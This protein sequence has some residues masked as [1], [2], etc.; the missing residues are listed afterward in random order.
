MS[1]GNARLER[2]LAV[3]LGIVIAGVVAAGIFWWLGR[4][5][6]ADGEPALMEGPE[7]PDFVLTERSGEPFGRQH[8]RGTV[9]IADFIFTNCAGICPRM[10]AEMAR[11]Q[12]DLP[13][14]VKFVSFSVDPARDTPDAL[15]AFADRYGAVRG[16]WYFLTGPRET[17]VELAYRI[18]A[19]KIEIPADHGPHFVL[20]DGLGRIRGYYDSNDAER[21][22]RLRQDARRLVAQARPPIPVK[23]LPTLNASLNG[24][25]AVLLLAG[26]GF[27]RSKRVAAHKA[28]MVAALG[29]SVLFLVSYLTYHHYAGTVPFRGQGWV[30][31]VYFGILI[32]HTVLAAVVVPL[33][34]FTLYRAWRGQ[35]DR[36]MKV[37]R[38]TFPLWLYVS[39]TGVVVYLMLYQLFPGG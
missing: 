31:P 24:L 38:W 14:E 5:P 37:A 6:G 30:R 39:V 34:L 25:S 35:F 16:R 8:L 36:H 27:I 3:G 26:F 13:E 4:T 15:R 32:S 29:C 21:M 33:A 1:D 19:Q 23:R 2:A 12:G 10:A 20:V 28:C 18:G 9:W 22:G 17:L 7:V 11:L